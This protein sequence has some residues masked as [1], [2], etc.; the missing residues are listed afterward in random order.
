LMGHSTG[1]SDAYYRPSENEL[2]DDYLKA[3]DSLTIDDT[4]KLKIEVESLRADISELEQKNKRIEELE[5]KQ[6]QFEL[7]FQSLIDSGIVKPYP[8]S[9]TINSKTQ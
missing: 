4:R 3:I 8:K 6:S 5:R 1:I 2:L 7:A 9:D